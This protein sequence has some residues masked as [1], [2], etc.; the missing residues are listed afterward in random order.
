MEGRPSP[1]TRARILAAALDLFVEHGYQRVSLRQIAE[2]LGLTKA[3]I[4][5]HFP[6]KSHVLAELAEP[7]FDDMEKALEVA[8]RHGPQRARWAVIEGITD[9]YLTHRRTLQMLLHDLALVAREPAFSRVMGVAHRAIAVIAGPNPGLRERVRAVQALSM[10]GDPVLFL[11]EDADELRSEVLAGVY[12]LLGEG[13]GF[14]RD[15]AR[16]R[17]AEPDGPTKRGG[18]TEPTGQTEP[19]GRVE[20]AGQVQPGRPAWPDRSTAAA[21]GSGRRDPGRPR[22]MTAEKRAAAR[23]MYAAGAYTVDEIAA[24]LGVSRATVY[25]H[26]GRA[27]RSR[28]VT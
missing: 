9:V 10:V 18:Q 26:L 12:L 15:T 5:Y 17:Q 11:T 8:V 14:D 23:T 28:P 24:A 4:L 3:A 7:V 27:G 25:R 16:G 22:A 1:D 2:R 13:T 19:G 21:N 20:P 6:S